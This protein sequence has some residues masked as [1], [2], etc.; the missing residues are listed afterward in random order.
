M[1]SVLGIKYNSLF[2]VNNN[3]CMFNMSFSKKTYNY[4]PIKFN[5][6]LNSTIKTNYGTTTS[7]SDI[8][9]ATLEELG[10]P[11][12]PEARKLLQDLGEIKNLKTHKKT[13]IPPELLQLKDSVK[14]EYDITAAD[15]SISQP[16]QPT[17]DSNKAGYITERFYKYQ[18][19]LLTKESKLGLK[20]FKLGP[21]SIPYPAMV[22]DIDL[23]SPPHDEDDEIQF[24]NGK[25][26]P[27][28]DNFDTEMSSFAP[29]NYID[30]AEFQKVLKAFHLSIDAGVV[31]RAKAH[32]N[33]ILAFIKRDNIIQALTAQYKFH[34]DMD[35]RL[36]N[37]NLVLN[38]GH[39]WFNPF[40]HLFDSP[41][42]P[43]SPPEEV[44]MYKNRKE[45]VQI[46]YEVSVAIF[47]ALGAAHDK[48]ETD[49]NIA[50][51]FDPSVVEILKEISKFEKK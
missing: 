16:Y 45:L 5:Y 29:N 43:P 33:L 15:H 38:I 25:F 19:G 21:I 36:T 3:L 48:D 17:M 20:Y 1:N 13:T 27:N 41:H 24:K 34:N 40:P 37:K 11:D 12:T 49:E 18:H 14:E 2:K 46:K 47:D 23:N 9:R 44:F 42:K 31:D 7:E 28:L 35:N 50:K 26:G 4:I 30:D 32:K 51:D 22:T 10:I 6:M 39:Y 8:P